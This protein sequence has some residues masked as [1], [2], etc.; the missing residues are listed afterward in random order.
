MTILNQTIGKL[1]AKNYKTADVFL[2]NGID[3]CCGGNISIEEAA[4]KN[5]INTNKLVSELETAMISRDV[6][7]DL[8]NRLNPAE[9]IDHIIEHHHTFVRENL[10]T[11]PPYLAKLADVH[12]ANHHELIEIEHLFGEAITAFKQHLKD[13]EEILFPYV[14]ELAVALDTGILPEKKNFKSIEDVIENMH[15]EH[16]GEGERFRTISK[17]TNNYTLPPEGCNTYR[18]GLEK[19]KA[20]EKDLHRHVH[21]ENNI[22]FPKALELEKKL[23]N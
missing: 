7:S 11:I 6:E 20:F 9:L 21:L 13:E 17:L 18:V 8:I 22:L 2:K 19:L 12:G 1:V 23:I 10:E 3:F 4:K 14:K 5:N 15:D 16:D